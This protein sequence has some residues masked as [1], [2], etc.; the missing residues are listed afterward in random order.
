M[1]TAILPNA[2]LTE[3]QSRSIAWV[4]GAGGLIGSHIARTTNHSGCFR[5]VGLTRGAL[6]LTDHLAV[7]RR[8]HEDS[9]AL[10]IHCAALS[11]AAGC[12][13]DPGAAR[14]VNIDATAHLA[15]LCSS[16]RLVYLSTDL[17]FDGGKGHYSETDPV[18]PLNLYAETKVAAERSVSTNPRHL[19][20]R[21]SLNAGNSPTGDRSF[22]EHLRRSWAGHKVVRLFTDEFRCPIAVSA[23]ARA[24][25]ELA[26]SSATGILHVAGTE[27]LSRFQIGEL[28]AR[29]W[30][31]LDGLMRPASVRDFQ[32]PARAAD[33]SLDCARAQ[34][35]LSFPLPRF[36]EW[37][38]SQV[39]LE[40]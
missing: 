35:L 33:C 5:V 11:T 37:L 13:R 18:N 20:L 31:G 19:I 9:P 21:T 27:R 29:R 2:S 17:V 22:T 6:D 39:D 38:A 12:D 23:T 3:D 34:G 15:E 32:G 30:P 24:V 4:T 1:P 40:G 16:I 10:V 8:F 26:L 36:S 25:W 28:L 7:R 14:S